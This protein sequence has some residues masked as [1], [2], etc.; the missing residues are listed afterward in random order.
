MNTTN[1]LLGTTSLLLV[2]AF[3]LSFGDFNKNRNSA[4]AKKA[5]EEIRAKLAAQEALLH[6][7]QLENLRSSAITTPAPAPIAPAPAP[8]DTAPLSEDLKSKLEAEIAKLKDEKD[9]AELKADTNEK[10]TLVLM[11][12]KT[13]AAQRQERDDPKIDDPEEDLGARVVGLQP[14][15]ILSRAGGRSPT[16][17]G[18]GRLAV[19][20]G[21]R[22][23]GK[24]LA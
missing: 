14:P 6:Q 15:Y 5:H 16:T 9:K 21:P 20:S 1:I 22:A 2:V 18:S 3:A 8:T 7:M 23:P 10:E 4:S 12:E 13:K 19:A 17:G 24:F 11:R